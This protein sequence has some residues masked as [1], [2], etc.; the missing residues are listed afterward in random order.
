MMSVPVE[1]IEQGDRIE[2]GLEDGPTAVVVYGIQE[3]K[4]FRTL[5]FELPSG[6]FEL[7]IQ[8]GH[9]VNLVC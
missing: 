5:M 7:N 2:V 8:H 9:T 6:S 1:Q 3:G 4:N